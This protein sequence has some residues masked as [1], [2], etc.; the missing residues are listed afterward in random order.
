[1]INLEGLQVPGTPLYL[2]TRTSTRK[3]PLMT[4]TG[5]SRD[6]CGTRGPGNREICPDYPDQHHYRWV[7]R[8]CHDLLCPV[9]WPTRA[10]QLAKKSGERVWAYFDLTRGDKPSH[11]SF[12]MNPEDYPSLTIGEDD[13]VKKVKSWGVLQAKAAGIRGSLVVP[14]LYRIKRE[15][16]RIFQEEADRR[17]RSREASR[18]EGPR[19]NRYDIVREQDHWWEY[20]DYAPHVHV[21]GYGYL[22]NAKKFKKTFG[23]VY[24]KHGNLKTLDDVQACINYLLSHVAVAKGVQVYSFQGDLSYNQLVVLEVNPVRVP[25]LCPD[26]GK[27]RIYE[28]TGEL[29]FR[30]E[31][32]RI[33]QLKKWV[34]SDVYQ[35]GD[36]HAS[37]RSPKEGSRKDMGPAPGFQGT[38]TRPPKKA[39]L[40][41]L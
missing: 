13:L 31:H 14:H 39:G 30:L 2:D 20:V 24:R 34:R 8:S 38:H 41:L 18:E 28:E 37:A 11:W 15:Y 35:G 40:G 25:V 27:Q 12:N 26:C 32:K 3:G 4:G 22:L 23:F 7:R 16:R 1:M 17:N 19:W 36:L 9:C 5:F 33:F 6:Y 29:V 10:A 21:I